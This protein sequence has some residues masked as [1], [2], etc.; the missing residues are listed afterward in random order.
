MSIVRSIVVVYSAPAGPIF[1]A[2]DERATCVRVEEERRRLVVCGNVARSFALLLFAGGADETGGGVG[3]EG[4]GAAGRRVGKAEGAA[5]AVRG[6]A[7]RAKSVREGMVG[8]GG[9]G[10]EGRGREGM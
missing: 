7:V 6:R 4:E 5:L 9:V 3:R 10:R 2:P 1:P 8:V